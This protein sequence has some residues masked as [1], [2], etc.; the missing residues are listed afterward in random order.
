MK[1][2]GGIYSTF[3]HSQITSRDFISLY[4]S[5]LLLSSSGYI[6]QWLHNG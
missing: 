3:F 1:D 5:Y 2:V 4:G 6:G